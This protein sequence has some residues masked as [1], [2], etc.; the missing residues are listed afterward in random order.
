MPFY[1]LRSDGFWHLHTWPGLDI[2]LTKSN[3][4]RSFR[5]LRDVVA[6]A[7]LDADLWLLQVPAHRAALTQ[8]WPASAARYWRS[9][10]SATAPTCLSSKCVMGSTPLNNFGKLFSSIKERASPIL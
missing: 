1:H 10:L 8:A 2:L 9:P 3:S 4:V 5:H 6:Y 7:T